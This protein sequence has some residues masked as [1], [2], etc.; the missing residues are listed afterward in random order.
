MKNWVQPEI[1]SINI[2]STATFKNAT[3]VER[4]EP[5]TA[6]DVVIVRSEGSSDID[7]ES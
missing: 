7:I 6:I 3:T 1:N 4:V 2:D 5:S